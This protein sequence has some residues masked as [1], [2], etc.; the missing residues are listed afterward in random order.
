MNVT[1][2]VQTSAGFMPFGVNGVLAGAAK[3][4]FGFVGF[5]SIA[6]VTANIYIIIIKFAKIYMPLL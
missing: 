6:A 5:D 1:S 4:F 3:C 2:S